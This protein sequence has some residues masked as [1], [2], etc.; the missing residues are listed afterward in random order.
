MPA[1]LPF[2]SWEALGRNAAPLLDNVH[3]VVIAGHDP[4]AAASFA[5][6]IARVHGSTRRVAIADLVGEVGP[7]QALVISEEAHGISDSF[8]YG[9]SLNKIAQPLEGSGNV[10]LMPSGTES[11][12]NETV[13]RNDR[14]R[15][16]AAGFQQV[17]ALLLVVAVP[18]TPGFAELCGFVGTVFPMGDPAPETPPGVPVI[19]APKRT[20][21]EVERVVAKARAV[22]SEDNGSRRN[23]LIAVAM[24]TIALALMVGILWPSIASRLPESVSRVLPGAS[25][26][27]RA[28]TNSADS[29][30]LTTPPAAV[31]PPAAGDS[32]TVNPTPAPSASAARSLVANPADS[33]SAAAYAVYLFS[34]SSRET[35]IP[36]PRVQSL[37]AVAITPVILDGD[38]VQWFRVTVGASVD[39]AGATALL[40]R[41]RTARILG[42]AS[43]TIR[44]MPFAFRLEEGL[45]VEAAPRIIADYDKRGITAYALKQDDGRVSLFTGAHETVEQA[46]F[47]AD[48]LRTQGVKAVLV[49]RTGRAF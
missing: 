16:L 40:A 35:A 11:V 20:P 34:A 2:V 13:Y 30:R 28:D 7:L 44:R 32:I 23:R 5:L 1:S 10:F 46:A 12:A 49:Y 33:A 24:L 48:S 26:A 41:L 37:P 15:K 6:G 17:G 4:V 22:G 38:S 42:Q 27:T 14:W 19:A 47:L 8:L 43:G 36:E 31:E 9:V 3:A 39:E 21:P 25:T 45:S 29:P 18:N